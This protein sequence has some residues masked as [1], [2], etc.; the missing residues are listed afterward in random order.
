[1]KLSRV[2]AR[3]AAILLLQ[4]SNIDPMTP[5]VVVA[6]VET[7]ADTP[8]GLLEYLA[9]R[10]AATI[11][12]FIDRSDAVIV[13]EV[14]QTDASNV[15]VRDE[16]LDA[17]Q[18]WLSGEAGAP[19]HIVVAQ[20][21]VR[22]VQWLVG[23]GAA[24]R[25]RVVGVPRSRRAVAADDVVPVLTPG[26]HGLLFLRRAAPDLPYA[27]Y[28]SGDAF[29]L[30]SGETGIRRFPVNNVD[31]LGNPVARDRTTE[32][33]E[34]TE[35]IRWYVAARGDTGR[36]RDGLDH[37]NPLIV[38]Q[39]IRELALRHAEGASR[40]FVEMLSVATSD[41]R[42]QLM[43][44]WWVLGEQQAARSA[45]EGLLREIGVETF[46]A[47]WGLK[48]SLTEGGEPTGTLFGPKP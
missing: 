6:P 7:V 25:V 14:G 21:L 16:D 2:R 13:G 10:T 19:P 36:L 30:L 11:G 43:L 33:N 35:A 31:N 45:F 9:R 34:E 20:T 40:K 42:L 3:S 32:I 22:V 23:V 27:P 15:P 4:L 17:L 1:M 18:P 48:H 8:D 39:A 28:L 44:G 38:R 24:Q 46:L 12:T 37:D 29:Q 41:L 47:Q 5:R 26:D